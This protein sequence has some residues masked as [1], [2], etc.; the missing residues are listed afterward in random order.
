MAQHTPYKRKLNGA[1]NAI[2]R[3]FIPPTNV[4]AKDPIWSICCLFRTIGVETNTPIKNNSTIP[5]NPVITTNCT[6]LSNK[7][8]FALSITI[9]MALDKSPAI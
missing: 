3:Q 6:H 8:C 7:N 9:P 4:I 2:T 1:N 5:K